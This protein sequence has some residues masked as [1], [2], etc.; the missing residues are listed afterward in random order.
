MGKIRSQARFARAE[1]FDLI[2]TIHIIPMIHIVHIIHS[3]AARATF[4]PAV[5]VYAAIP[6]DLQR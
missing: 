3:R 6:S 1:T 5:G 4:S 2:H